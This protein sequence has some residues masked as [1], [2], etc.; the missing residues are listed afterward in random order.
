MTAAER[1]ALAEVLDRAW[2]VHDARLTPLAGEHDLTVAVVAGGERSVLKLT[3]PRHTEPALVALQVHALTTIAARAP[4][5]PVPRVLPTRDGREWADVEV[6]GRVRRAWRTGWLEGRT[7]LDVRPRRPLLLRH[8]GGLLAR[9]DRALEGVDHPLLDR[10]HPW[11]PARG[12]WLGE[13]VG[14]IADREVRAQV[15]RVAERWPELERRLAALPV[16]T[17]HA[18][19]NDHNVVV[20]PAAD[21]VEVTGLFDFGDMIRTRRICEPAIAAAYAAFGSADPLGA[22][23]AV[24]A[25]YDAHTRLADEEIE[26]VGDLVRTRLA[27]SL[28]HAARRAAARPG[29]DYVTISQAPAR[30]LLD[31][32][33]RHH[34]R[35]IEA[36]LR[37][38]CGRPGFAAS[39]AVSRWIGDE[40]RSGRLAPVLD[41][42]SAP[43]GGWTSTVLD[44]GVGSPLL[45]SD[46]AHL[47]TG[48][49]SARIAEAMARD[50]A[51][52]G[53]GRWDEARPIYLGPAFRD[54]DHPTDE[55][56][57]V[58]LGIDLFVE[59]GVA[60][61]TPLPGVVEAVADNPSPKDYGPVV[62]LRHEPED[63]PPFFTLWGHL[64]PEVLD[65]LRPGDRL[66][67]GDRVAR[68]GA[69]PGNGD[70]PPHL[71]LQIVVDLLDLGHDVPGVAPPRERTL[72]RSWF[73]DPSALCGYPPGH[74]AAS[75]APVD[76]LLARRAQR[77]GT[78]LTLHHDPPLHLVRGW[79]QYLTDAEGRTFLDLFNN[80]PHVGHA[81]PRVVEAVSRQRALLDTH[82]RYLH[83]A[84]LDYA[85]ALVARLPR[86]LERVWLVNS[87]SEANELA[88][89]L[90]RA[91]TGR[92]EVIVQEGGYHGLTTT[93]VA[94][95]H[96]K[97]A[98]PGG[99][100]RAEWVEVV[101][102]PDDY[103]GRH[104]RTEGE[105][106]AAVGRAWAAEVARRVE[107]MVAEGRPPGAFL[108]E[109]FPSVAGQLVPPPGYLEG[110]YRAVRSAG[111]ICIADEVQTGFGRLGDVF[112]GFETQGVVPDVVVLGKPAG[113]GMPL[114]VVIATREVAEA[115]DNGME[116][117]STFGGNPVAAVAGMAVLRVIDDEGLQEAARRVGGRL[118]AG[119][120][121]LA[122]AHPV[123]GDVRG[124]GLFIGV[125][126]V[127]DRVRRT[128][129]PGAARTIRER[130]R[131]EGVLIGIDGP[132]GNVLKIRGPLVVNDADVDHFLD[133]LGG[134]LGEAGAQ[135]E[136]PSTAE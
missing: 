22:V 131:E 36:R 83:E 42:A 4:G 49:L 33:D 59:A 133:R 72:W 91:A 116:F 108:A 24:V 134:I 96:H 52:V 29:D 117:F 84:I 94:V 3:D 119:L 93:L 27:M 68:V 55:H 130:L 63:V 32:L 5:L 16:A 20:S 121:D 40:F 9:L 115:F 109:T 89:R 76:E 13:A 23:G 124:S 112:W 56:R 92:R 54:G 77:L 12:G 75:S 14:V 107:Q 90:A 18:D 34:P 11:D 53:I 113:N 8:L 50:G 21:P 35:W 123:I 81:H 48:P 66:A 64:D 126:L 98:G 97:F 37:D 17:I 30:A 136:P 74:A 104:R 65:R 122:A 87:G 79:Q 60:L 85:D 51:R 7:L 46:P 2:G 111:G 19:A 62:V 103:R 69:P 78:G 100:G 101:P 110:V 125:D 10:D 114:G 1:E 95:S 44:L 57:T 105:D 39:A 31:H 43:E 88:L 82:T 106:P 118:L 25:G 28:V 135:P 129:A 71:H 80:V 99:G 127:T 45:G 38:A 70:W 26:V 120:R 128:P 6:E 73:P 132:G 61:H 47:E 58:H 41:P 102:A 15:A 67:S 86:G